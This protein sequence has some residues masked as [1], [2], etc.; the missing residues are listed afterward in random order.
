MPLS[1]RLHIMCPNQR[2]NKFRQNLKERVTWLH[3]EETDPVALMES[4]E[5]SNLIDLGPNPSNEAP[6]NGFNLLGIKGALTLQSPQAPRIYLEAELHHM[7]ARALSLLLNLLRDQNQ[8]YLTKKKPSYLHWESAS[9][10]KNQNI[11]QGTV[12][13]VILSN[14]PT[15]NHPAFQVLILN[16]KCLRKKSLMK[17]KS[18]I[19]CRFQ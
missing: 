15:L 14:L 9:I 7:G 6:Q 18:C 12:L 19:P 8:Y 11:I 10:V 2:T 4:H 1:L 5:D 16:L 13:R 17:L 3:R